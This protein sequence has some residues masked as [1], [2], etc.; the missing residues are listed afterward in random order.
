MPRFAR[1]ASLG[2]TL[3]KWAEALLLLALA[4]QLA[5]LLWV[6]I[7]PMGMLGEWQPRRAAPLPLQAR[8]AL[9]QA[10]DPFTRSQTGEGPGAQVTGL[11][12]QLFGTRINEGSGQGS[13]IIA[14]PDGIQSSFA[15]G[16]EIMPGVTLKEVGFDHVLID[17]GGRA[18]TLFL[19]Q[20]GGGDAGAGSPA[21]GGAP[22]PMAGG[23]PA[24]GAPMPPPSPTPQSI[25]RDIAFA[26]RMDGGRVSGI[27]VSP[28]G[29]S[30]G[31]ATAGFQPGDIITQIN[32]RPISSAGDLQSLQAQIRPG[33][34]LS[35]MVERGAATVPIAI[36][37][38]GAQ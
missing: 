14:G 26:P 3:A 34:R 21:D 20:S 4:V 38:S 33:A 16:E 23:A 11:A 35:L 17:R 9:F 12:L 28:K 18:E 5:R 6:V 27:V 10:F 2:A 13:A 37:L 30:E 8:V 29:Q 24:P 25:Q 36:V 15:V 22:A 32:G 19:D 31:F 1:P 7:V